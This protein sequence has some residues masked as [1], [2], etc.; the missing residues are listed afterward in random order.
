MNAEKWRANANEWRGA[1]TDREKTFVQRAEFETYKASSEKA[2]AVEKE[3]SDIGEG[4]STGL[5]QGWT[6]LIGV[7]GLVGALIGIVIA[8]KH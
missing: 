8:L 3:R 7:V 5:S 1:M 2:L 4:K 6:L